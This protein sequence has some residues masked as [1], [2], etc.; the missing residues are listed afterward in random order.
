MQPRTRSTR[1]G[2]Q[3][4]TLTEVKSIDSRGVL[5]MLRA[6]GIEAW[7]DGPRY[8]MTKIEVKPKDFARAQELLAAMRS[9]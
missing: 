9:K 7:T 6:A 2:D 5:N 8:N 4:V 1:H 3:D